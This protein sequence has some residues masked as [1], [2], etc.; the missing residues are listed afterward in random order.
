MTPIDHL[1]TEARVLKVDEHLKLL[2]SQHLATCLQPNHV[3]LPIVTA[4]SGP[5]RMKQSLKTGFRDQVNDLLV[6]GNIHDIR[7]TRKV[8]HTRAVQAA[9]RSRR[10]NGVLSGAAPEVDQ[11]ETELP[12]IA[13][14]T[15]AQLR[16]EYC[17]ALE[18]FRHRINLA[19]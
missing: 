16:S 11:S 15:L 9:I 14:T 1:H 4:D 3:S 7:T 13:R 12:R 18:T 2:C 17:S 6:D 10:L 19:P 5:R 8:L